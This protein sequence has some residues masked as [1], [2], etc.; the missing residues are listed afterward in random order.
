MAT[1]KE[2]ASTAGVS[3]YTASVVLNDRAKEGRISDKRAEQVRQVARDL[4]YR[5]HAG[6]R[7]IRSRRTRQVGVLVPNT[8][9]NRFTHPLAYETILGIN[10]GLQTAGYMVVMARLDDVRK[11]LAEQSRVFKELVLDG[12]I[13]LDSMPREVEMKLEELI[14]HCV[15]CDSNVWRDRGCIRR[16]ERQ[17]GQLAGQAAATGGYRHIM[18]MTYDVKHLDHFSARERFEGV[19]YAIDATG[20][21]LTVIIEPAIGDASA[22]AAMAAQ[23]QPD[24]AIICNSVYQ[25]HTLRSI[26]EEAGKIPGRDFGLVCCD[27]QHQLDRM[28]PNLA[29]VSY[30]RYGMGLAAAEMMTTVLG[31]GME[32]AES[33]LLASVWLAG[34]SLTVGS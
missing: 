26:A 24:T 2:V 34:T 1:L 32:H 18:M 10:E 14:P 9:G 15:W 16:D 3:I 4:Q 12:M 11:D 31:R 22:R 23:L 8:P 19:R 6:A 21:K 25:A 7:S 29:R 30:D 33:K 28:W 27:D 17:A 20:Q 13:V 5:A